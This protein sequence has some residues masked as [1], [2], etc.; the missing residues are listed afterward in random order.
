M[1]M[2]ID[3]I[4]RGRTLRFLPAVALAA[5]VF[6]ALSANAEGTGPFGYPNLF[7]NPDF[8]SATIAENS[9]SGKWGYFEKGLISLENWTGYGKAG[10]AKFG[11]TTWDPSLPDTDEYVVFIQMAKGFAR[12]QRALPTA[13]RISSRPLRLRQRGFTHSPASMRRV[14]PTIPTLRVSVFSWSAAMSRMY[15]KRLYCSHATAATGTSCAT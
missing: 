1:K 2:M 8:E 13:L 9:N 7:L 12:W 15:L 6:V 3:G 5:A 14:G 11:N 4:V 10:I